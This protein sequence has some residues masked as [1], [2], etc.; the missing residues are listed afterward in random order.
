MEIRHLQLEVTIFIRGPV[1]E[2]QKLII[3]KLMRGMMKLTIH[4]P[5]EYE[6]DNN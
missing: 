4:L 3:F 2:E 5:S 1:L 6:R